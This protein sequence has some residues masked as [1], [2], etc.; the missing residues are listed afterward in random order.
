MQKE[1]LYPHQ[2]AEAKYTQIIGRLLELET[3]HQG[4]KAKHTQIIGRLLELEMK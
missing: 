2:D 1:G 3:N 4:T